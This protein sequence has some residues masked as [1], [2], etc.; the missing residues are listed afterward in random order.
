[1]KLY[2]AGLLALSSGIWFLAGGKLIGLII[3][4]M[5]VALAISAAVTGNR[6]E[7]KDD[8]PPTNR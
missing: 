2:A 6:R 4:L 1:M 5:A 7:G 8:K 3:G